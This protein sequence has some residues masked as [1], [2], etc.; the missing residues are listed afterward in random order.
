MS[1]YI[2]GSLPSVFSKQTE[3]AGF[4]IYIRKME[5]M[6]NGTNLKRQ[7]PFVC[8]KQKRKTEVCFLWLA[9]DKRQS[10]VAV[11]ANMPIYA[12]A[13]CYTRTHTVDL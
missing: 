1:V 4:R 12:R 6:E 10:T 3:V 13:I 5:L 8:S 2:Q 11:S 9:N 7:L